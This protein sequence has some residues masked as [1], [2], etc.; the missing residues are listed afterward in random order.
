[1]VSGAFNGFVWSVGEE[2]SDPVVAG[3]HGPIRH[4][5]YEQSG[6]YDNM[7]RDLGSIADL[8]V[9]MVRYGMPW[10]LAE[11]ESGVFDWTLWD[12]ALA[13]AQDAGLT[14]IVDL[15]HF[16][17][18]DHVGPFVDSRWVEQFCR[19]AD[20][21]LSRYRD[22]VWFTPVN[23]PGIT[24]VLTG[25]FGAWNDRL[26]SRSDHAKVLANVV[27]A[28]LEVV[29]RVRADRNGWWIGSE[30]FDA[31]VDPHGTDGDV[32]ARRRAVNWLVWDLHFGLD[33]LPGA[34]GY[35]DVVD[36]WIRA[37]IAELAVTDHAVAG[38][39]FY[40]SSVH[41][42]SDPNPDWD[43]DDLVVLGTAEL[44]A[45][46][47]R[48]QMPFWISETSNLSLPVADQERWLVALTAGVGR[49]IDDGLPVRGLCWYSRGDQF[50]WETA[51]VA[52]TGAITEVG[53]FDVN[54]VRRPAADAFARLVVSG[55]PEPQTTHISDVK[56]GSGAPSRRT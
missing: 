31:W 15:L 34:A 5:Q 13:G 2:G 19:Y 16:G 27:L 33:P 40:P 29:S 51:L 21:F 46:Y 8:G 49:M 28:N 52:P 25:R 56:E 43:I 35:L 50:D 4:D 18:P 22:L 48:Y 44:A 24:A 39:D 10:R 26:K 30:G 55:T 47:D 3:D 12:R 41:S 6:H 23:E 37:R 14:P 42:V 54:R 11:P 36:D 45:W 32:V 1:M 9:E 7:E 20:A 53:L 17:I 38:H